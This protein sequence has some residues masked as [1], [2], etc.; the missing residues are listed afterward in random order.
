[1]P[2]LGRIVLLGWV[3]AGLV[4]AAPTV[5]DA[6]PLASWNDGPAKTAILEFVGTV[7]RDGSPAFV[8]VAERFATFDNDGTLWSEQ[9]AYFQLLFVRDRVKALAPRHPE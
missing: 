3:T 1:M 4:C 5:R 8:P 2:Q 6:D 9:P 7:T